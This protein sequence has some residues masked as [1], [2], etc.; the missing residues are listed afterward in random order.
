MIKRMIVITMLIA[1]SLSAVAA[2]QPKE[3]TLTKPQHD[4]LELVQL[5]LKLAYVALQ[6]QQSEFQAKLAEFNAVCEA[7]VKEAGAKEGTRCNPETL[8]LIL[9]VAKGA[10]PEV[11]K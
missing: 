8:E 9:P 6:Q 5:R 10:G 11:K 7:V 1:F 3:P 2:D 4:R